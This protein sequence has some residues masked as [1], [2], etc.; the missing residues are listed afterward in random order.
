MFW[1]FYV[2]FVR[3]LACLCQVVFVIAFLALVVRG[4]EEGGV[5]RS[6]LVMV[7]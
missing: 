7:V 4:G 3:E 2:A 6:D 1:W 5:R